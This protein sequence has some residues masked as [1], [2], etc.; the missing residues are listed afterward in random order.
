[1]IRNVRP[2]R[3]TFVSQVSDCWQTISQ[4]SCALTTS[5]F[6]HARNLTI[7]KRPV[8]LNK[9]L[10]HNWTFFLRTRDSNFPFN[11]T[12]CVRCTCSLGSRMG[13]E[14][15]RD[16][17]SQPITMVSSCKNMHPQKINDISI[18]INLLVFHI[19]VQV[20]HPGTYFTKT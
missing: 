14:P 12:D 13:S 6:R 18:T 4:A 20:L 16:T 8:I 15:Y 5:P 2:A 17:A 9:S 7:T 11:F 10:K 3:P 1:M 19:Q